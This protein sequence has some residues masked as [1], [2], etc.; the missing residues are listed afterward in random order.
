MKETHASDLQLPA[1]S[2]LGRADLGVLVADRRGRLKYLNEYAGRLFRIPGDVSR[3]AGSPV[4]S[5]GLFAD[6]D[7]RKM[8]DL[9][10][11]VLRGRSWRGRSRAPA[12]TDHARSCGPWPCRC[13]AAGA[14]STGW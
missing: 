3:L 9:A 6:D 2:V 13:A 14:P 12:V 8:D 5:I 11:Q 7:L 4:L 1:G 10:A